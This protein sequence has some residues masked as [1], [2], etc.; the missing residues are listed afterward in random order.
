MLDNKSYPYPENIL[1]FVFGDNAKIDQISLVEFLKA[2]EEAVL[3]IEKRCLDLYFKQQKTLKDV[4]KIINKS[5][6]V[7][8]YRIWQ[9]GSKIRRQF[10]KNQNKIQRKLTGDK[11]IYVQASLVQLF[12]QANPNQH[13][14]TAEYF[15]QLK[16]NI[17]TNV[18]LN[19]FDIETLDQF[20]N[21]QAIQNIEQ[22]LTVT[23][24]ALLKINIEPQ[25]K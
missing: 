9:A 20:E 25:T 15:K 3:P 2:E 24:N 23:N 16:E 11:K 1:R 13:Q 7:P 14:S 10:T 19:A 17:T 18:L 8:D 5:P 4:A 21:L 22:K 6:S 12:D